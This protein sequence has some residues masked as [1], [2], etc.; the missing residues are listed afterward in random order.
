[1]SS[2]RNKDWKNNFDELTL[3]GTKRFLQILD[4]FLIGIELIKSKYTNSYTIHLI[5]Y[6]L[7]GDDKERKDG[8]IFKKWIKSPDIFF[9]LENKKAKCFNINDDSHPINFEEIY[10]MLDNQFVKLGSD[11]TLH[12]MLKFIDSCKSKPDI[13]SGSSGA[14][15]QIL[16]IKYLLALY[17]NDENKAKEILDE[18]NYFNKIWDKSHFELWHGK[19]EIWYQNLLNIKRDNLIKSVNLSLKDTNLNKIKAYCIK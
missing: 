12:K 4:P 1:M 3:K 9:C 5:V 19:F 11:I 7:W 15:A 13:A 8:L 17:L 14:I 10:E 18:L 6:A 2:I 16:E